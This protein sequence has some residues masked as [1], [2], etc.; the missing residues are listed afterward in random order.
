MAKWHLE[1][2]EDSRSTEFT[3]LSGF[4]V[5]LLLPFSLSP[6][7]LQRAVASKEVFDGSNNLLYSSDV[8]MSEQKHETGLSILHAYLSPLCCLTLG[9]SSFI[10]NCL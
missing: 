8:K 7:T 3:P 1:F 6:V 2:C 4:P 10:L 9:H 5:S